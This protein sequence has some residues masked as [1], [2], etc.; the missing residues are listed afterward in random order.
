[1]TAVIAAI[2]YWM[3][4][5]AMLPIPKDG[6]SPTLKSRP[7]K[8]VRPANVP[9]EPTLQIVRRVKN[10]AKQIAFTFDACATRAQPNGFDRAVFRLLQKEQIP[11]TIFLSGRWVK[12]HPQAM[13]ELAT[14]PLIEFANHS[15][16]HL[17]LPRLKRHEIATEI[18]RTELA[19]QPYGRHSIAFR[20]PFGEYNNLVLEV[21]HDHQLPTVLWDVVSGDPSPRMTAETMIK[22]VVRNTRSGSILIFHI[23]GRASQTSTA[24][25]SIFRQLRDR[26]FQFV[27]LSTLLAKRAHTPLIQPYADLKRH[28][29]RSP[30]E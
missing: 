13:K 7:E 26:G 18:E 15:Y 12:F 23:N 10:S 20:P 2:S 5:L 8:W 9:K 21:V 14:E 29:R 3:P 6:P 30:I 16:N 25:P 22:S 24:L 1:M 27:H 19:L 17:H 28:S 11:A 4:A